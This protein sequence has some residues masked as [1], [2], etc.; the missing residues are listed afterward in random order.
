MLMSDERNM[1]CFEGAMMMAL[2]FKVRLVGYCVLV[3]D[4]GIKKLWDS[5]ASSIRMSLPLQG[6]VLIR[7][8]CTVLW[9]E[10]TRRIS[11]AGREPIMSA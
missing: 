6:A 9:L 1:D 10:I 4:D 3:G 2:R 11:G 8:S 5:E 7:E